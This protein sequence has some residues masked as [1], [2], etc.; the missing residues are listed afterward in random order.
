M[1][2]SSSDIE[3]PFSIQLI[4]NLSQNGLAAF[5]NQANRF[6][7]GNEDSN[8]NAIILRSTNLHDYVFPTSLE[9]VGRAGAGTNNIPVQTL[10][11]L[12]IPVLN[13]PGANA[14]AVKELALAGL[15]ISS[16]NICNAWQYVESLPNDEH[17]TTSIEANKKRFV[18]AELPGKTLG[19][20]GL[21]K[22][23]VN[24]ANAAN[25]L[26]MRVLG[27]DPAISVKN[28]WQLNSAVEQIDSL[29][30][31]LAQADYLTLHIPLT[32][33]TT[34]FI[35]Q[36]KIA[37]LKNKAVVLNFSR[38]SIVDHLAIKNALDS[39]QLSCYVSD[40]PNDVLHH[41]PRT[42]T[43]PHLGAST[44][45]AQDN[46]ATMIS[47]Q[48]HDYLI[49]GTIKHSVNFPSVS[50]KRRDGYR[51]SISNKNVPNMVAQI[52]SVLSQSNLNILEMINQSRNGIAYNLID[53]D[54][55]IQ[56]HQLE[57]LHAIEGVLRIRN[58]H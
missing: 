46:C 43:L 25:H 40:F 45:E 32:K 14:N 34:H 7:I 5:Q 47:R 58:L 4:D 12:G 19:V 11:D 52:S 26:G 3:Q 33:E 27:F 28:A 53:I 24:V 50:L 30:E 18:G 29:P 1:T 39:E 35:D 17:L 20:I 54:Q 36:E 41:H 15:L 56:P 6:L 38:A 21:G 23:G 42:I 51:I 49:D 10:T 2:I 13:T 55:S 9:I 44:K 48:I 57:A 37:L 31:L 8:A 22:I 16:R